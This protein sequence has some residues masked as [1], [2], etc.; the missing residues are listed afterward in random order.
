MVGAASVAIP[1]CVIVKSR[2]NPLSDIILIVAVRGTDGA[3]AWASNFDVTP[4]RDFDSP[5]AENFDLCARDILGTLEPYLTDEPLVLVCGHSRGAACANLL[6]LLL[7][8][9]VPELR[10]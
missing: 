8:D 7:Q 4:S 3:G 9:E 6:G 2:D 10:Q 5:Y 1:D